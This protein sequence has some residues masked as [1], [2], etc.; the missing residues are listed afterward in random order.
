MVERDPPIRNQS[1][2]RLE[3]RI[4]LH[5]KNHLKPRMK[6]QLA[7]KSHLKSNLLQRAVQLMMVTQKN[8]QKKLRLLLKE[9]DKREKDTVARRTN[10]LEKRIG[11]S[12]AFM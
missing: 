5:E 7:M 3:M 9:R 6:N 2:L 1:L 8:L 11:D 12:I 4:S 10:G